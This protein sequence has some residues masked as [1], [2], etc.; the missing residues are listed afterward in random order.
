MAWP[1]SIP[2][3]SPKLAPQ[4]QTKSSPSAGFPQTLCSQAVLSKEGCSRGL[5]H[6][7]FAHCDHSL[8]LSPFFSVA[9]RCAYLVRR[10]LLRDQGAACLPYST[11]PAPLLYRIY[12]VFFFALEIPWCNGGG[13][14][15]SSYPPPS[16]GWAKIMFWYVGVEKRFFRAPLVDPVSL[17]SPV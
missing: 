10:L 6:G 9:L 17:S 12:N 3:P 16:S 5:H 11:A 7:V 13:G 4:Q 15:R 2:Q 1:S 14:M 8:L